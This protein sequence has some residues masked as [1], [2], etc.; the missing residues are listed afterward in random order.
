M[1]LDGQKAR[2][3]KAD[4]LSKKITG[5][6]AV[7]TLCIIQV[8]TREESTL[9]IEQKKKFG[10]KVGAQVVHEQFPEDVSEK[11]LLDFIATKNADTNIH[12]IIVQ[13]PLPKHLN[14]LVFCNAIL[15]EKDIDGLGA[16]NTALLAEGKPMHIPAT[17]K[18][19]L[20]LLNFYGIDP[21]GKHAVVVGRSHL[22][23]K[24]TAAL[25]LNSGATVTV[26]HRGTLD[27]SQE[28]KSAVILVVAAG[29]P[30]LI[31]KNQVSPGQTIVDV[32]INTVLGDHLEEEIPKRK[33][34]GDVS[35]DEVLPI[36]ENISPVPGGVGP[37]TVLSLFE[38]LA[39]AFEIQTRS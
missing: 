23:G 30:R 5:F 9:Y 4:I 38:N 29:V 11:T 2:D 8:G 33:I 17:A 22:V 36:V 16:V 25:L 37:M 24:P 7:P 12:G 19:V 39:S 13:M 10:A 35:F 32:G 31:G 28:T 34:V 20:S 1:I 3:A 18:G 6:S 15:P 14:P 21:K 26:C 27:L